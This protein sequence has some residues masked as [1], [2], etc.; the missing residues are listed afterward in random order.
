MDC[1]ECRE[2]LYP[3]LD[4]ELDPR[5]FEEVRVHLEECGGCDRAYVV[6]TV[7]VDRI[8]GSATAAV[9]PPGVRERLIIRLRGDL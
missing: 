1:D 7:F 4:R 5:E 9:A 8:R 6:E 2:R 3:Y